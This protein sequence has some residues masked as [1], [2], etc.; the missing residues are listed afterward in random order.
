MTKLDSVTEVGL[1]SILE[2]GVPF[3][4]AEQQEYPLDA[5]A[6]KPPAEEPTPTM[7]KPAGSLG[8]PDETFSDIELGEHHNRALEIFKEFAGSGWQKKLKQCWED[9]AYGDEIDENTRIALEQV[10]HLVGEDSP[11][12]EV[13]G[14]VT[15]RT[16]LK[17]KTEAKKDKVS[18]EAIGQKLLEILSTPEMQGEL[19]SIAGINFTEDPEGWAAFYAELAGKFKAAGFLSKTKKSG[20]SDKPK[21]D[22]DDEPVLEP[23]G[24][25]DEFDPDTLSFTP[26]AAPAASPPMSSPMPSSMP[27]MERRQ[28]EATDDICDLAITHDVTAAIKALLKKRK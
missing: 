3:G 24:E 2:A 19:A 7:A 26:A 6:V 28:F 5:A 8:V 20:S 27:P 1:R 9:G 17:I 23:D 18:W 25:E 15:G 11:P 12:A 14:D 4:E 22:D 16:K 13:A 10:K 21:K